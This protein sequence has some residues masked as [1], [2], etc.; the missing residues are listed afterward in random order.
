MLC[1]IN[2]TMHVK[3]FI[4][5][6][7]FLPQNDGLPLKTIALWLWLNGWWYA[8][9]GSLGWTKLTVLWYRDTWDRKTVQLW[10][11]LLEKSLYVY[12]VAFPVGLW[13][14][15]RG[16]RPANIVWCHGVK[17]SLCWDALEHSHHSLI[18]EA[19]RPGWL[20]SISSLTGAAQRQPQATRQVAF[21]F[22]LSVF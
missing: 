11:T 3:V 17:K 21:F 4:Q 10:E 7:Y 19:G 12:L 13:K 9:K 2:D 6:Q 5:S 18:I 20:E 1:L 14:G 16:P 15:E 22:L 8:S